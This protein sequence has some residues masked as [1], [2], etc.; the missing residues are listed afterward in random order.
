MQ[1]ISLYIFLI[2]I[3]FILAWQF[4]L[5]EI[6]IGLLAVLVITMI[7]RRLI[8]IR[9]IKIN[10]LVKIFRFV[11]AILPLYLY[12]FVLSG[13]EAIKMI[14]QQNIK[15]DSSIVKMSTKL[16]TPMARAFLINFIN[17]HP[18]TMAIDIID[19][20]IYIYWINL[21]RNQEMDEAVKPLIASFE[22]LLL[23]VFE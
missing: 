19:N 22:Q 1:G 16:A 13:I 14:L 21:L 18:H 17:L 3:W 5:P 6:V 23:E 2:A 12:V 8:S 11:F 10:S 7:F 4:S 9:S 15:V 20:N